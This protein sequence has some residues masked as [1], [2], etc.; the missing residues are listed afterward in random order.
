MDPHLLALAVTAAALAG[1]GLG[2]LWE[3]GEAARVR[4]VAAASAILP[5][6]LFAPNGADAAFLAWTVILVA[7]FVA[8]AV[9]DLASRTV[10]DALVLP[11]IALGLGHAWMRE[12]SV[13]AMGL[14][15]ALVVGAALVASAVP[16]RLRAG[17][18]G[19][20]VLLVAAA[21]AWLGPMVALD[22]IV[23]V[24]AF[25]LPFAGMAV[26]RRGAPRGLPAAPAVAAAT[27]VLWLHG[28]IL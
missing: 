20:D 27:L 13:G 18:G 22:L 15:V 16:A 11:L 24:S 9:V 23:L 14:A 7:L 25:L 5:A 8:L 10:P 6:L 2:G 17:V 28:P 21:L 3:P 19:G 12:L 4:G 1:L 26:V